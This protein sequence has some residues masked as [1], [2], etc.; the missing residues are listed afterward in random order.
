MIFNNAEEVKQW[1]RSILYI[2]CQLR[3]KIKFYQSLIE[4][5]HTDCCRFLDKPFNHKEIS[6]TLK[7]IIN[8]DIYRLKIVQLQN[9]IV[10]I[11]DIFDAMMDTLSCEER[12]IMT[13]KYLNGI[14]WDHI[15]AHIPYSRRQAI[16][17]HNKSIKNLTCIDWEVRANEQSAHD[18]AKGR[19][20]SVGI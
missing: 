19:L 12:C 17:I 13:A 6:P 11:T 2:K 15:E 7:K 18:Q 16:R 14:T 5:I 3:L 8:E 20:A 1:L 9:D 4:D 10:H